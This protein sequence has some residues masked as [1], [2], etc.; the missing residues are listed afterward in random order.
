M[1]TNNDPAHFG[2]LRKIMEEFALEPWVRQDV[3]HSPDPRLE[4]PSPWSHATPRSQ[5][6][7]T[8]AWR[9]ESARVSMTRSRTC[10][11]RV[12]GWPAVEAFEEEHSR[13]SLPIALCQVS[14]EM[15]TSGPTS[16]DVLQY[17][18]W[19]RFDSC[20][21]TTFAHLSTY[22]PFRYSFNDGFTIAH[23]SKIAQVCNECEA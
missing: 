19:R 11:A 3:N 7:G 5:A 8:A 17:S 12:L 16:M 6:N 15:F 23:V 2:A 1:V 20:C 9:S 21:T 18:D 10:R 22:Q 13:N 4:M 14:W